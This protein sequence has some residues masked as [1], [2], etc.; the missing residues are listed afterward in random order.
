[1]SFTMQPP[2]REFYHAGEDYYHNLITCL[3]HRR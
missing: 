1:M 3:H 2:G